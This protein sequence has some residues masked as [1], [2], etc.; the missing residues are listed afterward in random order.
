MPAN[1]TMLLPALAAGALIL[2]AA[3]V[4]A[5]GPLTPGEAAQ[6]GASTQIVSA[7]AAADRA[8]ARHVTRERR[9]TAIRRVVRLSRTRAR[10]TG[11]PAPGARHRAEVREW[12]TERLERHTRR[13]RAS[14]AEL[15][16]TG[17]AP[18]VPIPAALDAIAQ[19]ESGGDPRAI[20]GGGAY[21]G[22]F[23]FDR[24]TWASVGGTGDPAAASVEEQYRRAALLY[25]RAGAA[26]WPVCGR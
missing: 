11:E 12:S 14:V 7:V 20:G 1:R 18:D 8:V 9:T 3:G 24:G 6:P 13:L 23:Q 25:A 10:L 15:R 19:C 22:L 26:P 4:L 5:A 16:R 2:P 17:G 21:R